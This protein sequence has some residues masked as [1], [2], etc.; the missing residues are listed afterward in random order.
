MNYV[1]S[2]GKRKTSIARVYLKI[3]SGVVKVNGSYDYVDT[4]FKFKDI[5]FQP[6]KVLK[7]E[8]FFDFFITVNG[9]GVTGQAEA[10]RHGISKALMK[11]D[12]DQ[13]SFPDSLFY[14]KKLK[15]LGFLTRDP[16][17]VERKKV[18]RRKARKKEQYSKR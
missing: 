9:G 17:K 7:L 8:S 1:Y 16:R 18:G 5:I 4:K 14:K 2:T 13:N 6:L 15:D 11:F 10:I 12:F 3:G